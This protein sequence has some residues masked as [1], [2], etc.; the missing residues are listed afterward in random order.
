VPETTQGHRIG[1]IG[2]GRMG[3]P[4]VTRLLQAGCD[5]A[6][7]NRTRA[8]AEPLSELGAEIVD[9]P[10]G[11]ADRDIVFSTVAGPADFTAVMF[12][13]QGALL[14]DSENA[15]R[16]IVDCSTISVEASAAVRRAAAGRGT[17]LLAAPVSGNGRHVASGGA[18]FAVSGPEQ[19]VEIVR[20]YLEILGRGA[21]YIGEQDTARLVKIAHNLFLG[22]VIQS[23]IET[24][25]LMEGS[26]VSRRAYLDFINDSPM[27]SAF[28]GYK[29][30]AL[31]ELDWTATFTTALLRK[32][33]DLGLTAAAD[34]ELALPVTAAVREQ[35]QAAIDAGHADDDFASMLAVQAEAA[36]LDLN[37][38]RIDS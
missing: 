32:D 16:V 7:Y 14:S 26:G 28:S 33:L 3:R 23:L 18:L 17:T 2:V 11:L 38:P 35:V 19:E 20:P 36:G 10:R 34:V 27:G 29:T 24:S 25:L 12:D 1:W 6:V 15:P 5:V 21:H 30:P 37:P 8:T 31:V 9:E 13:G 22:A 4:L